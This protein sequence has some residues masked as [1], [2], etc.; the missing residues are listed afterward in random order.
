[1][2]LSKPSLVSS[3][4]DANTLF[5]SSLNKTRHFTKKQI[6]DKEFYLGSIQYP[7]ESFGKNTKK[8]FVTRTNQ[9]ALSSVLGINDEII[10]AIKRYGKN[11][12]GV[13]IG[14]TTAGIEENYLAFNKG[15]DESKY[16]HERNSFANTGEFIKDL[17]GLGGI[18]FGISTA[19][20]SGIKVFES[21]KNM[22][23]LGVCDAVICGG[24]DS[25]SSLT[26][27]GFNSLSVLS[28][29]LCKPFD[30]DRDGINIGEG[31]CFFLLS[32]D[33]ISNIKIKSVF[34]NCDAF[35]I[36]QPNPEATYQIELINKLLNSS[37]LKS[38]DYVNLHGTGTI[39]NDIMEAK[40]VYNTLKYT[41]CSCIKANIGHTLGAA[42]IIEAAICYLSLEKQTIP[43]QIIDKFDDNL[44]KI[45]LNI[46][47]KTCKIKNTLNLSFAF[48]GDN[49]GIVIGI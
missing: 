24:V 1:M 31:G 20:T 4:G 34:S 12:V 43:S 41:P 5:S 23:E 48:G 30:K 2:Y 28:Q 21:A 38:V 44:D 45:N 17:Y 8:E 14:T 18:C 25:I 37:N 47:S 10:K 6:L 9:I 22:I 15:F 13:I 19:C 33:E 35:H 27:L 29:G 3:A 40:A 32:K 36:T 46:V 11:R 49:A 16:I 26:V 7:L 42:G 39:A